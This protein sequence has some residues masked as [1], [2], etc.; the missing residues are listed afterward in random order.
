MLGDSKN[1]E[2]SQREKP[3]ERDGAEE[4][5]NTCCAPAL[6]GKERDQDGDGNRDHVG[7][8]AGRRDF[9][10]LDGTQDRDRRGDHAVAVQERRPEEPGHHECDAP[11][12][13]G[14]RG[15]SDQRGQRDDPS[16]TVV[17]G[18]HHKGQVLDRYDDDQGPQDQ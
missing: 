4:H 1:A 12:R 17:V 9:E 10:A 16:L 18:P 14:L 8:K 6:H 11:L 3:D 13:G 15:R 2:H 7:L 5:T